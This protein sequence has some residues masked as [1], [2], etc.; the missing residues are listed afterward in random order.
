[1]KEA[2]QTHA[3]DEFRQDVWDELA[4]G[5][6]YVHAR[7]RR[8][9]GGE[10]RLAELLDEVDERARDAAATALY[11]LAVPPSAFGPIVSAIGERRRRRRAGRG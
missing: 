7:L 10:D 5:M 4:A 6:R 8:R 11:Y 3:R 9:R 2:V 1:M